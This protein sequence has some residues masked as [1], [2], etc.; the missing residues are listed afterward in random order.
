VNVRGV[1][2]LYLEYN[3]EVTVHGARRLHDAQ[4]DDDRLREALEEVDERR[5]DACGGGER[6]PVLLRKH[7]VAEHHQ[8]QAKSGQTEPSQAKSS[9]VKS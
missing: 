9:Q 7:H 2:G 4:E 6:L 3:V 8:H 5:G 1:C